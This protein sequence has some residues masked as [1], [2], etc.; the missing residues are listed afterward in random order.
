MPYISTFCT[1]GAMLG[2]IKVVRTFKKSILPRAESVTNVKMCIYVF[3]KIT[4]MPKH[5][6]YRCLWIVR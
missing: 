2:A 5:L 4:I 6:S 1:H 3:V